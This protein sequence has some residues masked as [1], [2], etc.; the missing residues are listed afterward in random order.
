MSGM[1]GVAPVTVCC[2]PLKWMQTLRDMPVDMVDEDKKNT[3]GDP[4]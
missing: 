1:A 2:S 4:L 3:D